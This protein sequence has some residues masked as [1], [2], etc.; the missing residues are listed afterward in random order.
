M[1]IENKER[2]KEKE[3]EK[4]KKLKTQK[5]RLTLTDRVKALERAVFGEEIQ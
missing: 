3:K 5:G 2:K 4:I 1:R